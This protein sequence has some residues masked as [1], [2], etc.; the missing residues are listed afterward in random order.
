MTYKILLMVKERLTLDSIFIVSVWFGLVLCHINHC[1]L[2]MPNPFLYIKP[3]LL[4]TIQFSMSTSIPGQSGPG[5]NG[6]E[7]VLNIPQSS[8]ITGTS[9]SDCLV[10]YPEHF[11]G[12]V[13][14]SYSPSTHTPNRLGY[15]LFPYKIARTSV[16]GFS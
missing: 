15:L 4:Q 9:Q 14:A 5:S 3:V 13:G 11:R 2:L 7:G 1:R 16:K 8:S 10:S 6:N 12:A